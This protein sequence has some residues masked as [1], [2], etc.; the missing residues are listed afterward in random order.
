MTKPQDKTVLIVDD[1]PDVVE[2]FKSLLT[3]AGFNVM[4][5]QNGF[6]A[7]EKMKEQKPDFISLD[8]VMP[9][10]S[11]I[12]FY[13]ELRK[14]REWSKIPVVIVTAHARDEFGKSDF[15]DMM[16]GKVISGPETYLEK[17]VRPQMYVNT[18]KRILG[19]PEEPETADEK[20]P[21]MLKKELQNLLNSADAGKLQEAL[22]LLKKK[23]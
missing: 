17:P 5:A 4:T 16:E 12:K 11:G 14:N 23:K 6:E 9:K 15:S 3:N 19:I 21:Q 18:V 7:L 1:E 8:L 2:Y 10:K 22:N 13:Y 20:S